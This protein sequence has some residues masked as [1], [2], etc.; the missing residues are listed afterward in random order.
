MSI[1]SFLTVSCAVL[2]F[3]VL[4]HAQSGPPGGQVNDLLVSHT[5]PNVV[6][7]AT[8]GGVYR[9]TDGGRTW[10]NRSAGL[11]AVSANSVGGPSW[12]LYGRQA[13]RESGAPSSTGIRGTSSIQAF[14][15]GEPAPIVGYG[16]QSEF[17]G[18]DQVNVQIPDALAGAGVVEA[19]LVVDGI[20]T[21]AV[22]IEIQ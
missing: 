15:N 14:L 11:P 20:R 4:L 2:V 19:H 10:A 8:T 16:A 21:N 5:Q 7:A 22:T 12:N 9:S 1:R 18:L 3:C 6:F 13:G 17:V